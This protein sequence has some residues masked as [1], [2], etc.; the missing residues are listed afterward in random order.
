MVL[1]LRRLFSRKIQLSMSSMF[2]SQLPYTSATSIRDS[3]TPSRY[4][5]FY[6]LKVLVFVTV[7]SHVTLGKQHNMLAMF[8]LLYVLLTLLLVVVCLLFCIYY[9][10]CSRVLCRS[11]NEEG[12]NNIII[13]TKDSLTVD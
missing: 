9:V 1:L 11:P 6:F 10:Y 2:M 5:L 7:K 12:Y 4:T 8:S 3:N 13:D